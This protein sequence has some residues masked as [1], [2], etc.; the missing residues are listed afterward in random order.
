MKKLTNI[1]P[2]FSPNFTNKTTEFDLEND[3][4]NYPLNTGQL[5]N[6]FSEIWEKYGN[7]TSKQLL[8]LWEQI[9]EYINESYYRNVIW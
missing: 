3:S 7:T 5:A 4:R 1:N 6:K 2:M 8:L 9:F